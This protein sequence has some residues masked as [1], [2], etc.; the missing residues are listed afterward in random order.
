MTTTIELIK[1]LRE[2]TGAGV[3]DCRQAL[4]EYNGHYGKALTYLQEKAAAQAKKRADRISSQGTIELYSHA[5]G[6]IGVMVELNCETDFAARSVKF[7]NL[8]HELA[9]QIAAT[10]PLW[11]RDEDIPQE[12]IQHETEKSA[13]N[14]RADGKQ[15]ALIPRITAGYLKKYM[16]RHVLL[17]QPSIRD[18]TLT[19]AQMLAQAAAVV[20]ENIVLRRFVRWEIVEDGGS[21]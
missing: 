5:N 6:R 18:E 8:A 11:V 13:E 9:L 16:D 10:A 4:E 19:V 12:T 7:R 14:A 1:H 20:G 15:E 3:L 21:E 17:R 2:E